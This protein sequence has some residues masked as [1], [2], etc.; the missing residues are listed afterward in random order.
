[1]APRPHD[2]AY[3]ATPQDFRGWLQQ[4]HATATELWVGYHRKGSGQ[5]SMSWEE[6]QEQALCFGW[7]DG[8]RLKID[9]TRYTNRFTPRRPGSNWSDVNIARVEKLTA[10]GLM[11]EAGLAAFDARKLRLARHAYENRHKARFEPEMEEAFRANATAWEYFERQPP[12]YRASAT[13]WV[14][15]ARRS[16]TRQYRLAQLIEDCANGRRLKVLTSPSRR[17]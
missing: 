12:G 1:M 17:K 3:F 13:F 8:V 2:V 11:T 4:N 10:E 5:P 15:T 16:E 14:T 9:D 7:I 6:S